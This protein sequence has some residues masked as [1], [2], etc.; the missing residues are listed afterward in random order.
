MKQ[1]TNPVKRIETQ[2]SIALAHKVE[3]LI[4]IWQAP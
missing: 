2:T 3:F 1:L 4:I